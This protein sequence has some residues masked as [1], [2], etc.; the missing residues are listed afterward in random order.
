MLHVHYRIC[1]IRLGKAAWDQAS[2]A[3]INADRVYPPTVMV[4]PNSVCPQA[5]LRGRFFYVTCYS[6]L[7]SAIPAVAIGRRASKRL[8]N[9]LSSCG[10]TG[11]DNTSSPRPR[12]AAIASVEV[13]PLTSNAGSGVPNS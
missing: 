3:A 11:F 2:D 10:N 12:I 5:L 4:I 13:S 8:T 6:A 9:V 1:S 7:S